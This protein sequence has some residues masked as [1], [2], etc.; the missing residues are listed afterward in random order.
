MESGGELL[1][2]AVFL[3]TTKGASVN[4]VAE[5]AFRVSR[6]SV[7]WSGPRQLQLSEF[8]FLRGQW[9]ATMTTRS[10]KK[11]SLVRVCIESVAV[12]SIHFEFH[13]SVPD[14][15]LLLSALPKTCSG[16][17]REPHSPT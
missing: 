17:I 12:S 4:Q 1:V 7:R 6:E 2:H 14:V 3:P 11:T 15:D 5:G 13:V 8:L 9:R 16:E 10:P